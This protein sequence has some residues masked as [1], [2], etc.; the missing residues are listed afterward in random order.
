MRSVQIAYVP[1]GLPQKGKKAFGYCGDAVTCINRRTCL[2]ASSHP[3]FERWRSSAFDRAW[4]VDVLR[5][6]I[7]GREST[8]IPL[9]VDQGQLL[10]SALPVHWQDWRLSLIHISEPT[11]RTP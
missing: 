8:F 2:A 4:P 10:E 3:H 5:R 1:T 7:T 11:R 9:L 6:D